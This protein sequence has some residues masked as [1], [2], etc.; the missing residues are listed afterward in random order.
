MY[1]KNSDM[2]HKLALTSAIIFLDLKSF[3][4]FKGMGLKNNILKCIS[5]L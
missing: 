5:I 1:P 3:I 2:N 4:N